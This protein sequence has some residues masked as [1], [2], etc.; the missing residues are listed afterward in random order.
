MTKRLIYVERRQSDRRART[1]RDRFFYSCR[2]WE[3]LSSQEPRCFNNQPAGQPRGSL[4]RYASACCICLSAKNGNRR[5]EDGKD[6]VCF[7]RI[8]ASQDILQIHGLH[9]FLPI[10]HYITPSSQP[11]YG[12]PH[13][14]L[15]CDVH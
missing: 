15:Q 8:L 10:N 12:R 7:C 11:V 9:S 5:G 2:G 6:S 4:F 1:P 14:V 13:I 3:C